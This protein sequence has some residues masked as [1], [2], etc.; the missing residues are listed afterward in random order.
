MAETFFF[1]NFAKIK[2]FYIIIYF[3]K[4]RIVYIVYMYFENLELVLRIKW[5]ITTQISNH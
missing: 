4:R 3:C 5:D 2:Y 1:Y